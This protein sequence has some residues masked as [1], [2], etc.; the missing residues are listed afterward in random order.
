M[1]VS[2][3]SL[4]VSLR[5]GLSL[6]GFGVCLLVGVCGCGCW[7]FCLFCFGSRNGASVILVLSVYF[8]VIVGEGFGL[9]CDCG[10]CLL[11]MV[12]WLVGVCGWLPCVVFF[13]TLCCFQVV[14]VG[15]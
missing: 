6:F 14:C 8:V 5:S 1:L 3:C 11:V 15:L 4:A 12:I 7:A 10:T 2:G 9:F 13:L